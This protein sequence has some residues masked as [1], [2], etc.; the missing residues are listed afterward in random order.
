MVSLLDQHLRS[1]PCIKSLPIQQALPK[2]TKLLADAAL[3]LCSKRVA[4]PQLRISIVDICPCAF[5]QELEHVCDGRKRSAH[6]PDARRKRR[7]HLRA[8]H[9]CWRACCS[10]CLPHNTG[11]RKRTSISAMPAHCQPPPELDTG[12]YST[13]LREFAL[14]PGIPRQHTCLLKDL[15]GG[16]CQ[17]R[18]ASLASDGCAMVLS[19][20]LYPVQT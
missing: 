19:C 15:S 16:M 10:V 17:P 8:L 2:R 9:L 7:R 18:G 11:V 20:L 6:L 3:V 1:K 14:Q 13:A 5:A 12:P 4:L